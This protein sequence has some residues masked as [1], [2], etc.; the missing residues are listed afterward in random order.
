M[1]K[2]TTGSHL[3][4][5]IN[6]TEAG[7]R[8]KLYMKLEEKPS[9]I[10]YDWTLDIDENAIKEHVIHVPYE[11]T[12]QIGTYWLLVQIIGKKLN[13]KLIYSLYT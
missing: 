4:I 2:E 9:D 13:L 1:H 10:N 8:F 5:F 3:H 7:V 12:T 11:E 6:T